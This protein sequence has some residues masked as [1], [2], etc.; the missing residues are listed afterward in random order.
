MVAYDFEPEFME[1]LSK[2]APSNLK[3]FT[4]DSQLQNSYEEIKNSEFDLIVGANLVDRLP[5]P[6]EWVRQCKAKLSAKGLLIVFTPFT[7]MAQ[8]TP[9]AKWFGGVR[10]NAE[11][12]W[13]LHG[14]QDCAGPE[15]VLVQQQTHVP[16]VIRC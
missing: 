12:V 6:S 4:G 15:L 13:S 16:F 11:A 3:Y 7:W 5:D 9:P 8:W 2:R 10:R 1:M 14:L